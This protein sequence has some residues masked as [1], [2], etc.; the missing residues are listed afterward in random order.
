MYENGV[1]LTSIPIFIAVIKQYSTLE[2][3]PKKKVNLKRNIKI[4]YNKY[5]YVFPY[6]VLFK[7][8][9]F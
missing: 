3:Q 7:T 8:H 9:K 5:I 1:G 4:K 2:S 6:I